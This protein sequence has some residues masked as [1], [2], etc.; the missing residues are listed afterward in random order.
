MLIWRAT[1]GPVA[2]RRSIPTHGERTSH[3]PPTRH[4]AGGRRAAHKH[5]VSIQQPHTRRSRAITHVCRPETPNAHPRKLRRNRTSEEVHVDAVLPRRRVASH[6]RMGE[7]VV[8]VLPRTCL[9]RLSCLLLVLLPML[10]LLAVAVYWTYSRHQVGLQ[11]LSSVTSVFSF[12]V[13]FV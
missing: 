13:G 7:R 2:S 1:I 9:G 10:G 11:A 6:S 4:P 12:C 5:C 3:G 8:R